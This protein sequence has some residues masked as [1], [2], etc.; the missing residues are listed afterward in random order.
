MKLSQKKIARLVYEVEI[1]IDIL[2]VQKSEIESNL[3]YSKNTI[4]LFF[5]EMIDSVLNKIDELC[6][7]K[8][9]YRVVNVSKHLE[10]K[11]GL[12][13]EKIFFQLDK[14]VTSQLRNSTQAALF[15][16]TIGDKME[17]WSKQLLIDGDPAKSFIVDSVAST[18]V[19]T[20]T[21]LLHDYIGQRM[22]ENGLSI[23]NRYSPGYCNWP[24][25]EQQ[26]FFSLLPKDFCG[27]MLNESSLMSPVKSV[28]GIIGIGKEVK[29]KEYICDRCG[30]KDCTHRIKR[31]E[32]V[33]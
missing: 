16:C 2:K 17:K 14:I 30:V 6:E 18:V 9:G 5:S 11:D 7:I 19:E 23:T 27:V 8:A 26:L 20:V 33:K 29:Y 28:S 22:S 4:P 3:G 1:P 24:V 21:D 25:S 31:M 15:L 32:K 12:I 13:V 10:K